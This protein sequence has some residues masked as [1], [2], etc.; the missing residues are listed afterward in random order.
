[1]PW[2]VFKYNIFCIKVTMYIVET[3]CFRKEK[4]HTKHRISFKGIKLGTSLNEF[5]LPIWMQF[6]S[7][8]QVHSTNSGWVFPMLIVRDKYKKI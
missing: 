4:I 2:S 7:F 5:S 8:I 1:M 3:G 6:H